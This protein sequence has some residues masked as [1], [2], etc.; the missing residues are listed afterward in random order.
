MSKSYCC[1]L[2]PV[3]L[4]SIFF[5]S[6]EACA[7][8]GWKW[9]IEGVQPDSLSFEVTASTVDQFGNFY[10]AGY[11]NASS[12]SLV[13]SFG[14]FS[15]YDSTHIGQLIISKTDT[16]GDVLWVIVTQGNSP[17]MVADYSGNLYVYGSYSGTTI[18]I[19]T[20]T[21]TNTGNCDFLFKLSP[22][23]HV[24]WAKNIANLDMYGS[25]FGVDRCNNVYVTGE[26]YDS[27][28]I[29]TTTIYGSHTTYY[30]FIEKY[31][32]F[33]NPVWAKSF[34]GIDPTEVQQAT[35]SQNGMVY[36]YGRFYSF[37]PDSSDWHITIGSSILSAV[38][39]SGWAQGWF[40][41]KIDSS[42]NFIWARNLNKPFGFNDITTDKFDHVYATG[43]L[44]TNLILGTDTLITSGGGDAF[45]AKFDSSGHILWARSGGGG[46]LDEGFNVTADLCGNIWVIGSLHFFSYPA[47]AYSINFDGHYLTTPTGS[48]DPAFIVRYDTSGNYI[49]NTIL[50]SGG[51]DFIGISVDNTGNFYVGGDY[52]HTDLIF[53]TD[54][55]S[56]SYPGTERLFVAKYKYDV[57]DCKN[58]IISC[59]CEG[60][61]VPN[62]SVII[63]STDSFAYTGTLPIDSVRWNFG[64]GSISTIINPVHTY[65]ITDSYYVCVIAYS[66]CGNDTVCSE[67]HMERAGVATINASGLSMYPNPALDHITIVAH[68]PINNVAITNLLGQT[69]YTHNYNTEQVQVSVANLPNG[70]YIV[71]INGSEVRKFVKQ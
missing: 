56:S 18:T 21:L 51:D 1:L 67:V 50:K 28:T 31:D 61:P 54:T 63:G 20:I 10:I 43:Y 34:G 26:F 38:F 65:A 23:G 5:S 48:Y 46:S 32:Q 3:V 8:V 13:F 25:G 49:S 40:L 14:A 33:G 57:T 2:L 41:T 62:F 71:K 27:L 39:A 4:L 58:E 16:A 47:T 70:L 24:L 37:S 17:K 44:D 64:D 69:V 9:G 22:A 55:L 35:V 68:F 60:T 59:L 29:G 30:V 12:D 6:Y 11:H 15:V 52:W 19:D 7:Q 45:T 42:G 36:I 53:G 66:I